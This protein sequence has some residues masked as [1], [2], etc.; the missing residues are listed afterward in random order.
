MCKAFFRLVKSFAYCSKEDQSSHV[1][2]SGKFLKSADFYINLYV[3][4][5]LA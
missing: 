2:A 4:K 1:E 3:E 5:K